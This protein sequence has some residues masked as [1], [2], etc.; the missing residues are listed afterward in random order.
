MQ[1]PASSM[2]MLFTDSVR[3]DIFGPSSSVVHFQS[4]SEAVELDLDEGGEAGG[5]VE[6]GDAAQNGR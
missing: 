6:A 2:F 3:G 5:A 4:Q 1:Q